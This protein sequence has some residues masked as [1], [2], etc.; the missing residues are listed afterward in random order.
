MALL[1]YD[2][3][4]AFGVALREVVSPATPIRSVEHLVGRK[5]ELDRIEQAL[6]ARGRQIFIF[7]ERGV[8]KSSLAASAANLWQSSDAE[9]IDVSCAPDTTIYTLVESIAKQA[10]DRSSQYQ[11]RSSESMRVGFKWLNY[12]ASS[13]INRERL[14]EQLQSLADCIEVLREVAAFH[15]DCPVVV[16]DEVDRI[17]D[18]VVLDMLADLIKQV[19]DKSIGVKIIFTGVGESLDEILGAH[20]SA[21]RQLETIQLPRL[22]W[23]ARRDIAQAALDAFSLRFA[24]DSIWVRLAAVSDGYPYYVHLI[25]E[26]LLWLLF[27]REE[28]VEVVEWEDYF[29]A[30]DSAILS[31]H[32]DLARSYE[33]AVNHP[34]GDY[35]VALWA[36][37]ADEWQGAYLHEMYHR[38]L[39]I[40]DQLA[41][42]EAMERQQ[43]NSRIRSFLRPSH[44][45]VLVRGK[46]QGFYMYREKM[47][48]GYVRMQAEANRVDITHEEAKA[49]IKTYMHVPARSIGY[50][51][52]QIPRG[53]NFRKQSL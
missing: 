53:V 2:N 52:S 47:L 42:V 1:N 24:N 19:G 14:S 20:A 27:D 36:T 28:P 31:I 34:S 33:A 17:G 5:D 11:T 43:F 13:E 21:I 18:P 3:R 29:H 25:V 30:L 32:R 38:Y 15:S 16:V 46:K 51:T 8:G 41:G 35:E 12:T 22:D 50:Y 37:S 23:L 6:Y 48:R 7:G 9:Y 39:R 10:L 26:R 4:Q 49:N 40:V 44:G 45:E